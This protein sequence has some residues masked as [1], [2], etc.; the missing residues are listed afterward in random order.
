ML[1][2]IRNYDRKYSNPEEM[3][4]AIRN[5]KLDNRYELAIIDRQTGREIK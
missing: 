2:I 5:F 3:N 4:E 1:Q